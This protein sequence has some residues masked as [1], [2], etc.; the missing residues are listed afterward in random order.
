MVTVAFGVEIAAF[1][2]TEGEGWGLDCL[3]QGQL[4]EQYGT[5]SFT[6]PLE[7]WFGESD[8]DTA[9]RVAQARAWQEAIQARLCGRSTRRAA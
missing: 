6:L 2:L 4:L 8:R 1:E 5:W 3:D 9:Y 7:H